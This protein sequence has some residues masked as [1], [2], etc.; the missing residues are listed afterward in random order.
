MITLYGRASAWNVRKVLFFTGEIG[1]PVERLDYGRGTTPTNTPDFL[2]MNPNAMVPVLKDDGLTAWESHTILRYLAAK[3]ADESFYPKALERR[4][5]VDQ[6]LD[7]KLGHIS[8]PVRLLFFFHYLKS[9]IY[10]EK[11]AQAAEAESAKFFTILDG[12]L[13]RTGAFVTG[14][15]LT[16]ADCALGMGVHRWL[17]LPLNHPKLDNVQRYYRELSERPAFR[18]SVLI[19]MP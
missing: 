16:I 13:A 2:A 1:L 3:Y 6:W 7:W 5:L 12:Q 9:L 4:A 15:D 10:G 8:P 11:E 17:S 19:G 14:P 18:D